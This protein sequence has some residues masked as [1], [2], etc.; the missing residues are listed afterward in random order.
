ML[1]LKKPSVSIALSHLKKGEF[2]Y[3]PEI[4]QVY[5][6]RCGTDEFRLALLKVRTLVIEEFKSRTPSE[7][8]TLREMQDDLK[9]LTDTEAAKYNS[10]KFEVA[11]DGA[12][13]CN[14][15]N[16]HVDVSRFS[17]IEAAKHSDVLNYQSRMLSAIKKERKYVP[18]PV[19]R[20]TPGKI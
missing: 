6:V 14:F 20:Q 8:V 12:R 5:G 19:K 10:E 17:P 15:R 2:V 3:S 7:V 18:I 13:R 16:R 4:E 1:T 9:I 11:L